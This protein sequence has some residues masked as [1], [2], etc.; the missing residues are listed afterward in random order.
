MIK[1]ANIRIR[2][3]TNKKRIVERGRINKVNTILTVNI[4]GKSL[5]G[6]WYIPF[7]IKIKSK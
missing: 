2:L 4:S 6:K 3:A 1:R 5:T 7:P